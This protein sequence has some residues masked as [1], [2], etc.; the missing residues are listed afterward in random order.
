[1][2][3]YESAEPVRPG[4]RYGKLT[5]LEAQEEGFSLC[6]CDCGAEPKVRNILLTSGYLTSCGCARGDSRKRDITGMRSGAVVALEPTRARKSGAALWR[7]RCDCGNEILAETYKITSGVLKSCGCRRRKT[8]PDLAG[9]RFGRLTALERLDQKHG[10][11]Y[12]WRCRCDCGRETLVPAYA[13]RSGGIRSCGCARQE[14][15]RRRAIDIGGRRF[16]R[17]TALSPLDKRL[18][19]SVVWRCRCDCGSAV[20]AS[21]NSLAHG[22]TRSCGCLTRENK[23]L[24]ASLRYIDGAYGGL[25]EKRRL[26]KNN[27]SG[28]TGVVSY[29]GRWRAQIIFRHRAYNLGTYDRIEDAASARRQA[30]ERILDDFLEWYNETHPRGGAHG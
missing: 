10:N 3:E 16:G 29:R 12:L 30:E 8:P 14:A 19:G 21:Y 1:M 18:G 25:T 27:T 23:S 6:R 17:L 22:N 13:L 5:V 15:L 11:S 24:A 26:R 2:K 20:E 4:G 9:Q 7:C 28:Y